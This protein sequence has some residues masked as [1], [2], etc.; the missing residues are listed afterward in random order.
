MTRSARIPL[1]MAA[2]SYRH[3]SLHHASSRCYHL[4]L[5]RYS[6]LPRYFIILASCISYM[7]TL[8]A[9]FA[10]SL[11]GKL[12]FHHDGELLLSLLHACT[13][14]SIPPRPSRQ[15]YYFP[16]LYLLTSSARLH[17]IMLRFRFL[18]SSFDYLLYRFY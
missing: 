7:L 18:L 14:I 16:C 9:S 6:L 17:D 15:K 2:I 3:A 5:G 10:I 12:S 1:A 4:Y 11:V 13:V 8:I